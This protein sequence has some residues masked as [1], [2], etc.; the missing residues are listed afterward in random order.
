MSSP[1]KLPN[2]P[3]NK[4]GGSSKW[5]ILVLIVSLGA[6]I[7]LVGFLAGR[8]STL[9]LNPGPLDPMLGFARILPE[10][11]TARHEALRPLLR[12]HMHNLRPSIRE[13]RRAQRQIGSTMLADPFDRSAMETALAGFRQKLGDSQQASHQAFVSLLEHL[14][15]AE[16]RLLVDVLRREPRQRRFARPPRNPPGDNR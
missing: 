10:L 1:N 8:A 16:R 5:L 13:I 11:A 6:N 14:T 2:N 7:A 9:H 12:E 4:E 3:P 15:P